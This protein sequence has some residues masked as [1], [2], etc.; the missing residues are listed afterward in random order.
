MLSLL[1]HAVLEDSD[2]Y[3]LKEAALCGLFVISKNI[4]KASG[5]PKN[6]MG[7]TKFCIVGTMAVIIHANIESTTSQRW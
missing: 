2:N 1:E 5:K 3:N 7:C 4:S 6:S